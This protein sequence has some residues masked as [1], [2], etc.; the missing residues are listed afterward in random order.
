MVC[1]VSISSGFAYSFGGISLNPPPVRHSSEESLDYKVLHDWQDKR[2]DNDCRIAESQTTMTAASL[3]GPQTQI[4]TSSELEQ[5]ESL[6]RKLIGIASSYG[7]VF[8]KHYLRSRPYVVDHS[9]HPCISKPDANK[10]YP[11]SHAAGGYLVG[12]ALADKFPNK[13]EIIMKQA[14]QIGLN[15]VIGGVHHPSDI[16]AGQYMAQQLWEKIKNSPFLLS[17]LT[18]E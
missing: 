11:S 12:L 10:S 17:L 1:G 18:R 4:L 6:I 13:K 9:L 5:S 8:K 7:Y 14:E 2:T 15:R 3:F 16:Q